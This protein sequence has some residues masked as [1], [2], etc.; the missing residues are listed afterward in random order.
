LSLLLDDKH[1]GTEI[2]LN[3]WQVASIQWGLL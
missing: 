1:L 2:F 3:V